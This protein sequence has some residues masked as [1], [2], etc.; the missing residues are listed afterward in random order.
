VSAVPP[1]DEHQTHNKVT[2]AKLDTYEK[3]RRQVEERDNRHLQEL[4]LAFVVG[5]ISLIIIAAAARW[6]NMTRDR[7]PPRRHSYCMLTDEEVPVE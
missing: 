1:S 6:F 4:S 5:C 7:N 2:M 3:L